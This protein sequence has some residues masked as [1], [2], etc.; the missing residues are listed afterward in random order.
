MNG[1]FSYALN[2]MSNIWHQ[3]FILFLIS[4]VGELCA[5]YNALAGIFLMHT[6][7]YAY[8]DD[9]SGW[10]KGSF[11]KWQKLGSAP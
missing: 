9:P 11:D 6:L 5:W 2:S 3:W 10:F 7:P 1:F 8:I 4:W